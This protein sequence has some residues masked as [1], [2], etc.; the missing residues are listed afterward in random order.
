MLKTKKLAQNGLIEEGAS[1]NFSTNST[2]MYR[3]LSFVCL[4]CFLAHE[5][6]L[7]SMKILSSLEETLKLL[8]FFADLEQV[9]RSEAAT[10]GVL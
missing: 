6:T 5:D 10:V 8:V 4:R 7:P 2:I 1:W 9:I 3:Y